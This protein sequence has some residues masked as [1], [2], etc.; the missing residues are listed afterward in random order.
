MGTTNYLK[1]ENNRYGTIRILDEKRLISQADQKKER[2]KQEQGKDGNKASS[3][4]LS[5][6][7]PATGATGMNWKGSAGLK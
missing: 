4:I 7:W 3:W 1:L 2:G 6:G 5:L